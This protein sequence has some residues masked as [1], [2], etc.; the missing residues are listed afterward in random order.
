MDT[1]HA[2]YGITLPAESPKERSYYERWKAFAHDQKLPVTFDMGLQHSFDDLLQRATGLI[3]TSIAEGFGLAF[4]EP[5]LINRPLFGRNLSEITSEFTEAGVD[6]NTL[7]EE[8]TVPQEWIDIDEL[9]ANIGDHLT[10]S[11][12]AYGKSTTTEDIDCAYNAAVKNH[13]VEFAHLNESMQAS[14]IKRIKAHPEAASEINPATLQLPI[15]ERV[16]QS[17]SEAVS[18]NFGIDKYGEA[19]NSI[20]RK[21]MGNPVSYKIDASR[22]L[23]SFITPERFCLLRS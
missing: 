22:I 19:L 8:V 7:Y 20:Y 10:R 16:L 9:R 15:S 6:L 2:Q 13:R 17:N 11:R 12:E 23:E 4:L 5:W 1:S 21:V 14:V 3:T 18:A